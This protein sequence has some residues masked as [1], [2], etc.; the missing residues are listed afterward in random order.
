MCY[1]QTLPLSQMKPVH[2]ASHPTSHWPVTWLQTVLSL[3]C[4]KHW[5]LQLK[6]YNPSPHS[7]H[8]KKIWKLYKAIDNVVK[9]WHDKEPLKINYNPHKWPILSESSTKVIHIK[10]VNTYFGLINFENFVYQESFE[11]NWNF[12]NDVIIH[13]NA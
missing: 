3:Q 6:P 1:F 9:W 8:K 7:Y 13:F 4:P 10:I 11:L 2:P 12:K 5:W